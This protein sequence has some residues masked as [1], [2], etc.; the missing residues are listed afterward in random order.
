MKYY[1][2]FVKP[3]N[4]VRTEDLIALKETVEGWYVEYKQ[5]SPN[6]SAL[7]KSI[8]AFANTYGGWLFLGI[9][10]ESKVN[11]VAGTFLGILNSEVDA[12][13]QRMRKA[14]ADSINPTPHFETFVFSGPDAT[15][16]LAED[17]SI[18]AAWVP[19]SMTAPHIH[20]SGQIYRRVSDA[21]EPRPEK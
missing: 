9:A 6:A 10:E 19:E 21:S 12:V 18:I 17:R 1:S 5:E 3:I 7:A 14:A 20:K 8:S 4:D 2:P 13:L 15:I 11:A 16:G